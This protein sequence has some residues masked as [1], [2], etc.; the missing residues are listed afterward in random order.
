MWTNTLSLDSKVKFLAHQ[1]WTDG[2][3][4]ERFRKKS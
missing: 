4:A 3:I 2:V 1:M